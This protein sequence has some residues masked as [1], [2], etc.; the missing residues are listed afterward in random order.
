M[1]SNDGTGE[2]WDGS[3]SVHHTSPVTK[4][5]LCEVSSARRGVGA[6]ENVADGRRGKADDHARE[7]TEDDAEGNSVGL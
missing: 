3:K 1:A 7:N 6:V 4:L 5:L 2:S